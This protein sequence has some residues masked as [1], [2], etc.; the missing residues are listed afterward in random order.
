M[1]IDKN[2]WKG[3]RVLITG[4]TGFKGA[5]LTFWLAEM[6][7]EVTGFSLLPPT[8]PSMF[9]L[10]G[11]SGACTYVRGDVRELEPLEKTV[12]QACPEVIF[13]MAAQALVLPSY[14]D[15]A[16]TY[17]TNVMGTVNLLEAVR[18]VPARYTRSVVVVTTDKCYENREQRVNYVETDR[19]GGYDPYSS[20]KACAELVAAAYRNSYFN[21]GD[22]A[23]HK[24][25]VATARAGNV[26]GGGDWAENRILPD[27]VRALAKGEPVVLRR[28]LAVRPW[29]HVLEPLGGY[30]MLAQKMHSGGA[31]FSKAYNFGPDAEDSLTVSELVDSFCAAIGGS[32]REEPDSS[33]LHEAGLL[34]LDNTLAKSELGWKPVFKPRQAVGLAA[35]W[36]RGYLSGGDLREIT[37]AQIGRY[38]ENQTQF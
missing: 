5:W 4:N 38:N 13:H 32:V 31:A 11:L 3:R 35:Q 2:F 26:I 33:A 9:E 27:C 15:P 23:A 24:T 17:A 8:E 18:R 12:A 10:L 6:G 1:A 29:Q 34:M 7:A 14:R 16:G 28:P 30:L 22:Y 19:L 36:I 37:S 21:T 25:G 20:S